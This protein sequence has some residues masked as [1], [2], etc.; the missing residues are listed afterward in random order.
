MIKI[1]IFKKVFLAFIF[2]G[3]FSGNAK[4][5]SYNDTLFFKSGM[6]K[7]CEIISYDQKNVKYTYTTTKGE[8]VFPIIAVKQL[9]Y[10]VMY[11]SLGNF[12]FSSKQGIT[13][14]TIIT[15]KIDSGV[16]VRHIISFNPFTLPVLG[17][18]FEYTFRFGKN[19]QFGLHVPLHSFSP[20]ILDTTFFYAG[21]GMKFYIVN[22]EKNA[23]TF[24][25]TPTYYYSGEL[26]AAM[27]L[28]VSLGFVR[29]FTPRIA[30]D[31]YIGLG[32]AVSI[33]TLKVRPIPMAHLGFCI[34]LGKKTK[35]KLS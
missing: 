3:I 26:K 31:G 14:S 32:P 13:D 19:K 20:I 7:P 9:K 29:Y 4:S 8:V 5:Q 1:K 35:I 27:A 25:L 24:G 10:F 21:L 34:L 23:F 6:E 30:I 15:E 2:A 28:P 11:D 18:D 33:E 12:L 16:I 22:T 17:L